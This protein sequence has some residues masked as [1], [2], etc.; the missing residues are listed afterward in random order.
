[1]PRTEDKKIEELMR[2][3]VIRHDFGPD[4]IRIRRVLAIPDDGF[5]VDVDYQRWITTILG[6][7][8]CLNEQKQ[9]VWLPGV[10]RNM[11]EEI[12]ALL[13]K[14]KLPPSAYA[15]IEN[16]VLA[17]NRFRTARA[18]SFGVAID[19][20][21]SDPTNIAT[22]EGQ[23][24]MSG[25]KYV[26]LLIDERAMKADVFRFLNA[27]WD[28]KIQ[29]MLTVPDAPRTKRV[30]VAEN[31]ERDELI[32]KLYLESPQKSGRKKDGDIRGE[33][34]YVIVVRRLKEEYNIEC[35]EDNVK[36]VVSR[37][38]RKHNGT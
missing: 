11:H 33:T 6:D 18:D 4:M 36:T 17:N 35:S 12:A 32:Y 24:R 5:F 38:W 21:Y 28:S 26:R 37:M 1:M 10:Y 31:K 29:P 2:D 30:R 7:G 3:V 15:T 22:R 34:R 14:Y 20:G 9:Q 16:C 27:N 8:L 25:Q 23:W 13:T 19:R